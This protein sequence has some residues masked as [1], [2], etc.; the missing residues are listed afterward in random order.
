[1]LRGLDSVSKLARHTVASAVPSVVGPAPERLTVAITALCNLRCIG[2]RYG[3]D[4][5][6]NA[7]LTSEAVYG[8]LAD[9]AAVGFPTV[10]L[11]GGE[12][13]LHPNLPQFVEYAIGVGVKPV[14]TTNAILLEKR[15]EEL[16][17]AGLRSM[18]IGYY[19]YADRYDEYVARKGAFSHLERSVA[20]VR[21]KYG[22]GVDVQ[23][24]Y[25]LTRQT[26]SA[27]LLSQAWQFAQRYRLFFQVDLVHYSLPYFS[28]G[29]NRE[30][31]F[32]A[33]D[34]SN[35]LSVAQRLL[36]IKTEAPDLFLESPAS[37]RSIP[38]WALQGPAMQ[39]PCD[40]Y[41]MLWVGADGSVRLCYAAF[42]LGNIYQTP[43]RQIFGAPEH[44]AACG[45]AFKLECP[46]C[47]CERGSRIDSH[48]ASRFRYGRITGGYTRPPTV[49]SGNLPGALPILP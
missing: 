45:Q 25:L 2:C 46:H 34:H 11:Y 4:Y 33:S 48:L 43:L 40:A 42:P 23:I 16:Y 41:K 26:C 13:L 17:R 15:L 49:P 20:A 29:P 10:R 47:H 44:R 39:V 9:A 27:D 6:P 14:I 35:L 19:G 32:T 8:L 30:L 18:S 36:E 28:E 37:I 21:N 3:R 7:Q 31:Q 24:N 12:P 5:M 22:M 1:M 38:D